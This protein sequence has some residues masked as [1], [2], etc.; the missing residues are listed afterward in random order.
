MR[1]RVSSNWMEHKR[2]VAL[3]AFVDVSRN[4]AISITT[5]NDML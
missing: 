1:V 5:I 3:T 2:I 4:L